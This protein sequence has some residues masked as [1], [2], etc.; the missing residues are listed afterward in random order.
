M[1]A[2]VSQSKAKKPRWF[3]SESPALKNP[4]IIRGDVFCWNNTTTIRDPYLVGDKILRT[5]MKPS[6]ILK[7]GESSRQNGKVKSFQKHIHTFNEWT[8]IDTFLDFQKRGTE[9][10]IGFFIDGY[11]FDDYVLKAFP[12]ADLDSAWALV[13]AKIEPI[14]NGIIDGF[15][16]TD[17]YYW[18]QETKKAM[19]E[20]EAEKAAKKRRNEEAKRQSQQSYQQYYQ[21]ES[22]NMGASLSVVSLSQ[23]ETRIIDACYRDMAFRLHPDKNGGNDEDMKILNGL[24]DK[25]RKRL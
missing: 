19:D 18:W 10:G 24:K 2:S 4:R 9:Q 7:I 16:L 8:V 3:K 12:D 5:E 1:Y 23:D 13:R 11:S 21:K 15:K 25:I 6:Y 20:L 14:E 22:A 17:E